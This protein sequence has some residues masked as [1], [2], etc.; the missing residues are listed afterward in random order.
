MLIWT[1]VAVGYLLL[2]VGRR[3]WRKEPPAALPTLAVA[4]GTLFP[5]L[6]D[7]PLALATNSI[8]G[9]SLTHSVFVTA[10]VLVLVWM[11]AKEHPT[12]RRVAIAGG[13]G[14]ASHLGADVVDY[15]VLDHGTLRFLLW[16]VLSP[17]SHIQTVL[18]LLQLLNP[19]LYVA[20]Q[21]AITVLAI[22]LWIRDG[23]PGMSALRSHLSRNPTP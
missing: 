14:Y 4:V 15:F 8:P 18:D 3:Y 10:I 5:D 22:V 13:L 6:I 16:P 7:K 17:E 1:H 2:S 23:K 9:R 20:V 11:W 19:T 21:T 12:R